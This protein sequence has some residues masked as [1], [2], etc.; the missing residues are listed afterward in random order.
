MAARHKGWHGR[1]IAMGWEACGRTAGT[2]S[3]IQNDPSDLLALNH[4]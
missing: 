1:D 3:G 4:G 2:G